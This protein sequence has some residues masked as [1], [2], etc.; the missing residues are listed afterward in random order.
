MAWAW[1]ACPEA[2][3]QRAYPAFQVGDAL[4]EH[5]AGRV[6]DAGIDIAEFLQGK[7]PGGMFGVFEDV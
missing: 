6:H 5:I 4:F 1:A 7:Q 2:D 3:R